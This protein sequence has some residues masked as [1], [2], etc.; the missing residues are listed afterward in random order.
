LGEA[1]YP[2]EQ[3]ENKAKSRFEGSTNK[4]QEKKL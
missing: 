4:F 1:I 3:A 2:S